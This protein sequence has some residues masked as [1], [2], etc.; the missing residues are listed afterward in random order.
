MHVG[1]LDLDSEGLIILSNDGEL[2]QA[3]THPKHKVSKVYHVTLDQAFDNEILPRLEKGVHTENSKAKAHS[4]KRLSSRRLEVVLT[5]GMKRQI[6]YM[7]QAVHHR[8]KRLIR[9][10]IGSLELGDLKL[11]KWRPLTPQERDDL[12]AIAHGEKS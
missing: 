4:V 5:T 3:L 7:M 1:R 8:V 6:R 12:L 10:K 2:S 9:L 11:G